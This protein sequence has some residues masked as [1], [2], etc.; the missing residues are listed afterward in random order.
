MGN[1][2]KDYNP[3]YAEETFKFI[4]DKSVPEEA[5]DKFMDLADNDHAAAIE[6]LMNWRKKTNEISAVAG[7][8]MEGFA[9]PIGKK[10]KK[11]TTYR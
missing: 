2:P 11:K 3:L 9:G 5:K 4:F 1:A 7:G 6:F 8:G 10:K